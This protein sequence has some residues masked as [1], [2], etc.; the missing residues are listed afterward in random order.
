MRA[1]TIS[2]VINKIHIRTANHN[3]N[4]HTFTVNNTQHNTVNIMLLMAVL[5]IIFCMNHDCKASDL[6]SLFKNLQL[7]VYFLQQ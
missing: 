1:K 3:A 5:S 2:F 7:A 6:I 4:R